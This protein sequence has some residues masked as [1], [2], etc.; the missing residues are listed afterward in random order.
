MQN[1]SHCLHPVAG[2]VCGGVLGGFSHYRCC[3]RFRVIR[4]GLVTAA[5]LEQSGAA[6]L[7]SGGDTPSPELDHCTAVQV[8]SA[9]NTHIATTS[10]GHTI[11]QQHNPTFTLAL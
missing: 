7:V 9:A 8:R 1:S 3:T 5:S 10:P 2:Q 11:A 6:E 4:P